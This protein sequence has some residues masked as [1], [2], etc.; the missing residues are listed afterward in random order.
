M[1]VTLRVRA[2]HR[3]ALA[4]S[5][6]LIGG[7]V[8]TASGA[9]PL[10]PV[11]VKDNPKVTETVP[12]A[13][14]RWLGWVQNSKRRPAHHDFYVQ[15]GA[16]ARVKVNAVGTRGLGGDFAGRNVVYVQQCCDRPPRINR[17][18]LRS[19]LRSPLPAKVNHRR[20]T[21]KISGTGTHP[22]VSGVRG[23]VTV[24]GPWLLYS[25][26]TELL[27]V[28]TYWR[29]TVMLYNRV[30]H[31]L[32]RVAAESSDFYALTA[33]QV[34]RKYVAY[35]WTRDYVNRKAIVRRYNIKTGRTAKLAT[36]RDSLHLSG[37]SVSSDGT[38]YYFAT[39][40][41]CSDP[42]T[43]ELVRQAIGGP[44]D[45]IATFTTQHWWQRPNRTYV[46]DRPDGSRLVLF[47]ANGD[48]YKVLD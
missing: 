4:F 48:I 24:S 43:H 35:L 18:D 10:D 5:V 26:Y 34:N 15:R 29:H 20:H 19:G 14:G 47:D 16:D 32:R 31:E 38:V 11:P 40:A 1:M 39:E 3:L 45:V 41:D 23:D 21:V 36:A 33:G 13:A 42:C 6:V 12:S 7:A 37:P 27:D 9:A 25:G 44:A 8:A 22:V 17:F 28:D 30:T 46:K 2:R